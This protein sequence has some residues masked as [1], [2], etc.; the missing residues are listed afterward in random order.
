MPDV[1]D[2]PIPLTSPP[3]PSADDEYRA[4]AHKRVEELR[5]FYVH[6][7]IYT[8]VNTGLF[9]IDWIASPGTTWFFW[10]LL[11][12]G[13]GLAAHA[14]V[15]FLGGPFGSAWEERK[16]RELAGRYRRASG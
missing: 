10:P 5:G 13:I 8:I 15:T 16:T 11:G 2:R 6:V 9:A 4:R 7:S 3:V 12:W 14:V 1:L